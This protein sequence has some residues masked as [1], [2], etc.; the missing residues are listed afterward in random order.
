MEEKKD[1][2][3]FILTLAWLGIQLAW[4]SARKAHSID[5]G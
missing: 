2:F 5:D 3:S 4:I 1:M